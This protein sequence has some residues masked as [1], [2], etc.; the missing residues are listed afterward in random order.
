MS[1]FGSLDIIV[2]NAGVTRAADI[3]ELTEDDWDRIHRVNAKGIFLS[4][5]CSPSDDQTR[6]GRTYN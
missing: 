1:V 6:G 2:N 3:M 4:P 5:S